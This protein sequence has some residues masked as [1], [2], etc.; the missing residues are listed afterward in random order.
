[1]KS[2]RGDA[3]ALERFERAT[4]VPMLVLALAIVPL[5]LAPLVFDLSDEAED[6][7]EVLD[8]FIWSAFALEYL[9]RLYLAPAKWAFVRSNKIDLF[10]IALPFLRPLRVVRSARLL[11][12]LRAVRVVVFLGRALDAGHDV[13]RRHKLHYALLVT[14]I[15]CCASAG[16]VVVFEDGAEEA[17]IESYAEALWWAATTITTVGYGDTFPTTAA[18]RGVGVFLM[19]VGIGVF[20]LLA[21]SLASFFVERHEEEDIDPRVEEIT[22]RL[23]RIERILSDEHGVDEHRG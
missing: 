14:A 9:V 7:I 11:R 12:L 6:A 4:A 3:E 19:L 17:N 13:V 23:E 18:G 20:G 22:E 15:V 5:L 16:L 10:V 8:W 21:G 1:M 2:R